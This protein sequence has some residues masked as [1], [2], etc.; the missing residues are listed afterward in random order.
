M[1]KTLTEKLQGKKVEEVGSNMV[2]L[3]KNYKRDMVVFDYEM[4]YTV[5]ANRDEHGF[6]TYANTNPTFTQLHYND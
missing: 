3:M 1:T 5:Y 2:V 6:I 4:G